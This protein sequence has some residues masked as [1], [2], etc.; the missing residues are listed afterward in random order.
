M[1]QREIKDMLILTFNLKTKKSILRVNTMFLR[2]HGSIKHDARSGIGNMK[3]VSSLFFN[4]F[5]R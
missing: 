2:E 1:K 5:T 4:C 3:Y